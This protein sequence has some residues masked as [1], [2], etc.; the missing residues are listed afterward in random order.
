MKN[1]LCNMSLSI[2]VR[3]RVLR[4]YIEPILLY[5]SES[6]TINRVARNHIEATK[7]WFYRRM[8]RIP[9]TDRKRNE[10]VLKEVNSKRELHNHIRSIQSTF[11]GHI[12]RRG[13]MEHILPFSL[14]VVTM[15]SILP[16]L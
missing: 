9:W 10:D 4:S 12:M 11:F 6:W 1:I 2:E 16:L 8:L 3:K 5:R 15:C 14:P 13:K 7:F